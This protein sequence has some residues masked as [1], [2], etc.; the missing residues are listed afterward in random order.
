MVADEIGALPELLARLRVHT[1]GARRTERHIDAAF[2]NRRGGGRVAVELVAKLRRGDAEEDVVAQDLPRFFVYAH[3]TEFG[4]F[5]IG[6]RD[7]DLRAPDDRRRPRLPVNW[8]LPLHLL[9]VAELYRQA[10]RL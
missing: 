2:L 6:R 3:D 7:P 8:R 9:A 10:F 1:S 4:A 5:F